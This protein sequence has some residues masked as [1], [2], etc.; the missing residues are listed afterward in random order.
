M[1]Y[2]P[3]KH[4]RQSIRLKGYDYRRSGYYFITICVVDR[5]SLF[6]RIVNRRLEL[7][8]LGELVGNIWQGLPR[9]FPGLE[10]DEFVVMP[11]HFHGIL[12][13]CDRS[14]GRD[15]ID[16][17]G[18]P[19]NP[20]RIDMVS[21]PDNPD[22]IDMVSDPDN[23]DRIDMVGDPDNPDRI[24]MVGDPDNPDRIDMV[25]DPDNP[26]RIDMVGDPDDVRA[27]HWDDNFSCRPIINLPNASPLPASHHNRSTLPTS[28]HNRSPLPASQRS[29]PTD[30]PTGTVPGSMNA[31][32]QNFKSIS[33]RKINIYRQSPGQ[34]VWQRNYYERIIWENAGLQRVRQYIINNPR[35]W[36]KDK[37][38]RE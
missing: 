35:S 11:N 14:D 7:N 28:H 8:P 17:V 4:H 2:N 24:D 15:R 36:Q 26:D 33:T 12:R 23:P 22:R 25:G 10:I 9:S 31:I 5:S 16:M 34:Q 18:D 32:V 13:L 30:R 27:K 20:D 37:F 1:A 29:T 19:D 38:H 6:G 3:K 21:D